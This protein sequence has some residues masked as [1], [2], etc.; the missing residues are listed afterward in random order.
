MRTWRS[1]PSKCSACSEYL[2]HFL[3]MQ[4]R[5]QYRIQCHTCFEVTLPR[6]I[7]NKIPTQTWQSRATQLQWQLTTANRWSR[8]RHMRLVAG[9]ATTFKRGG[10]P[11][12]N[13][14][15]PLQQSITVPE[16]QERCTLRSIHQLRRLS[17]ASAPGHEST[18]GLRE[19]W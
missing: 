6:I 15:Q 2:F 12:R 14:K 11:Y 5:L 10:W 7:L 17:A 13:L 18:S 1:K 8:Q 9:G 16:V 19:R 3:L 4:W